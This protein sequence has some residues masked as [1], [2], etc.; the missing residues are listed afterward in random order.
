M[1]F[2][3]RDE[4]LNLLKTIE[5]KSKNRSYMTLIYGRRRVG[6]TR[7]IQQHF[8]NRKFL[9]FFTAKKADSLLAR[10]FQEEIKQK[11][12]I[13]IYG[14]P[15]NTLD[16]FKILVQLGKKEP[17]NV[18]FD[19]FQN[20][21]YVNRNIFAGIQKIWDLD[22]ENTD[23][24]INFIF[25]GSSVSLIKRIFLGEEEPLF[26]RLSY[27]LHLQPLKLKVLKEI[28]TDHHL[29]TLDNFID[30]YILSGGIPKYIDF[31]IDSGAKN[32]E[33]FIKGFIFENS[34]LL[35]EGKFSL[36]EEFGKKYGIYFAILQL[37][38]EGKT[39]RSEIL[40]ILKDAQEIGGYLSVLENS[41]LKLIAKHKPFNQKGSRN[42]RY[43]INDPFYQF[44]FRFIYKNISA[45]EAS[46][47]DYLKENIL[48]DWPIYRGVMFET[49]IKEALKESLLFNRIGSYWDRRGLNE[50][51]VVAIN[52]DKKYIL[53]GECKLNKAKGKLNQLMAKSI[54]L[55]K[56][57]QS[58][59]KIYKLFY[60]EMIDEIIEN[61]RGFLFTD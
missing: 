3:D 20:Y 4:E 17:I 33:A 55:E 40:S 39:K 1:E 56:E 37:I 35:E 38:S 41:N 19:E 61:P 50:V 54:E 36:I 8:K 25:S 23:T 7:L 22:I 52:D 49:F 48:R 42:I 18:V 59:Q 60:P 44:W 12:D 10:D 47:F 32:F 46:N 30:L 16:I 29:Y 27:R 51:D 15:E 58:C 14:T 11:F 53:M 21:E 43:I 45:V 31:F 9:Y 28:L 34:P 26:G 13:D 2:Y 6:K 24:R 5:D 57:F